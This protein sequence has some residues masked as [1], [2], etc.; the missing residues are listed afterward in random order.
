MTR[1]R[2]RLP[3][4]LTASRGYVAVVRGR[5]IRFPEWLWDAI[6]DAAVK[7]DVSVAHYIRDVL[8]Q[9][10]VLETQKPPPL[11]RGSHDHL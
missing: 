9:H 10:M 4:T 11:G 2:I 6:E 8:L 3:T 7:E 5:T 1:N